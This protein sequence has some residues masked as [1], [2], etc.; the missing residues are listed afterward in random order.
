LGVVPGSDQARIAFS[1]NNIAIVANRQLYYYNPTDGFRQITDPEIGSPIDIVWADSLFI[2]T[3]GES[4]YHSNITNEEEYEPLDFATAEFRPDVTYGLGVNEDNEVIAYGEN[5]TEYYANQG[6]DNFTYTRIS[7]KAIKLGILGTHCKMEMDAKWYVLGR[8][9]ES[10]P[11]VYIVQ[12]GGS[13]KISSREVD[14]IISEYGEAGMRNVTLDAILIDAVSYVLV[15]LPN[16]TLLYNVNIGE[17]MGNNVAWSTLKSDVLGDAAYRGRNFVRSPDISEWVGGDVRGGNIGKLDPSIATHFGEL[18]E[19]ILYTPLV[20]LE[21]LSVDV[22]EIETIP[23]VAPDEDATVFLSQTENGRVYSNEEIELY[24][25][26]F[27]Y[28]QR[29]YIRALGYIRKFVGYKLRGAS[30]SRMS[31]ANLDIE[32]S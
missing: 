8:R 10:S 28:D 32:A 21:S 7:L 12:G 14:K 26:N 29:F 3:D 25:D 11:G 17:S 16:K 23:G 1:F 2:L 4:I 30:R 6:S 19:W 5:T 24:G 31:F 27:D 18:A 15:H 9:E 20:D 22:F 13:K